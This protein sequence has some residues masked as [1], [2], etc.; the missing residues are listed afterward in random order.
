[1]AAAASVG[2]IEERKEDG[3]LSAVE[4]TQMNGQIATLESISQRSQ[5][6]AECFRR[7]KTGGEGRAR[8]QRSG[9]TPRPRGGT[10]PEAPLTPCLPAPLPRGAPHSPPLFTLRQHSS[11][12]IRT[13]GG[14]A[15]AR[16]GERGSGWRN[17][18]RVRAVDIKRPPHPGVRSPGSPRRGASPP[19]PP[20]AAARRG[21]LASLWVL[22]L[23]FVLDLGRWGTGS[24]EVPVCLGRRLAL[25][26]GEGG[27]R[28]GGAER[29][30]EGPGG[31]CRLRRHKSPFHPPPFP[32]PKSL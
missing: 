2:T 21:S 17:S 10:P 18:P 12:S 28:R 1:M 23:G 6:P 27:G 13:P 20:T 29:A 16:G 15:G 5:R 25:S 19:P 30:S 7:V 14:R 31:R 3:L 26:A 11:H 24:K 32:A 8:G 22:S 9:E 4:I